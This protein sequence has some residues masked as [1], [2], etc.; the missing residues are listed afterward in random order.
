MDETI[1][2]QIRFSAVLNQI[3]YHFQNSH[4]HNVRDVI[5]SVIGNAAFVIFTKN[6]L[7]IFP[8][9]FC[10]YS[11][12]SYQ[13]TLVVLLK[14]IRTII[15]VVKVL[16]RFHVHFIENSPKDLGSHER[17]GMEV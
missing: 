9:E 11:N 6:K 8:F 10:V 1:P 3:G 4:I 5:I 16:A 2:T 12:N 14:I 13:K 7:L 17:S 15:V